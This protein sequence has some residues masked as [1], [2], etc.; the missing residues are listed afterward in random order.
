MVSLTQKFFSQRWFLVFLKSQKGTNTKN[1]KP[2][3]AIANIQL[4]LPQYSTFESEI[5]NGADPH[6][7]KFVETNNILLETS[8]RELADAILNPNVPR[9]MFTRNPYSR[10]LSG[11]TDKVAERNVSINFH[12]GLNDSASFCEFTPDYSP[13]PAIKS[14]VCLSLFNFLCKTCK[15]KTW[16]NL[17]RRVH[18]LSPR[19][20]S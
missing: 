10:A 12:P 7:V 1:Q 16:Q 20:S 19:R 17:L 5:R 15:D 4:F 9:I 2:K 14:S 6:V 18:S 3:N 11:Y 8:A 13:F